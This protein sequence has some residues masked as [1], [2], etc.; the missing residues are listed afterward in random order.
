MH[1]NVRALSPGAHPTTACITAIDTT[2]RSSSLAIFDQRLVTYLGIPKFRKG[3]KQ[4]RAN[5]HF[6]W[7]HAG[8]VIQRMPPLQLGAKFF[9]AIVAGARVLVLPPHITTRISISS[10]APREA[11]NVIKT[12]ETGLCTIF[13][14]EFG[15]EILYR[16]SIKYNYCF[17]QL[18]NR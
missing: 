15:W 7:V 5:V 10:S 1:S 8:D 2:Y 14:R 6:G 3:I 16:Q 18:V 12:L 11:V 4:P 13:R 17:T 9:F